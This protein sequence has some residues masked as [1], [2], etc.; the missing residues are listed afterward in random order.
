MVGSIKPIY[1]EYDVPS[2]DFLKPKQ[3]KTGS[4]KSS[5]FKFFLNCLKIVYK[6]VNI[7]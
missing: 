6:I 7:F 5:N 2:A 4:D 3:K 1:M